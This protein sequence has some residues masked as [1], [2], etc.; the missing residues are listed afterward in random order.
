MISPVITARCYLAEARRVRNNPVCRNFYWV[1]LGWAA[2]ARRRASVRATS[3]VQGDLFGG[4][5]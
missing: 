1:L 2:A 5:L 4:A 3:V